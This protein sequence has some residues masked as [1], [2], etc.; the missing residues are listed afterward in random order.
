MVMRGRCGDSYFVGAGPNEGIVAEVA[1][2]VGGDHLTIYAI[3]R[4]EVLILAG[5]S[6]RRRAGAVVSS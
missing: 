3:P 4:N 5:R 2:D 1:T 6:V